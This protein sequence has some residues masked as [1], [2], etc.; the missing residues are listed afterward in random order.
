LNS[1]GI[2]YIRYETS[3]EHVKKAVQEEMEGPGQYL[4]YRFERSPLT[5]RATGYDNNDISF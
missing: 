5:L 3:K 4:G 1:V 2:K